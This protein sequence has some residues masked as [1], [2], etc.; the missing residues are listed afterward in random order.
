MN[1]KNALKSLS[2]IWSGSLLASGSS[3]LI[4]MILARELGVEA[5]GLF[6]SSIAT[7]ML[8]TLLAG[9][10]VS[11][12][13]LKEFGREGWN[14]LRLIQPS[15]KFIYFSTIIIIAIL[16]IWALFGPHDFDTTKVLILLSLFLIGQIG[17]EIV[18]SKFQLEE[19]YKVLALWQL[20]PNLLRL[21]IIIIV[22]VLPFHFDVFMAALIYS[23]VG[24]IFIYF[25]IKQLYS[26][27]NGLIDLK[28]H[29]KKNI[30]NSYI[31]TQ[32]EIFKGALPFGLAT[33]FGFI[34][35]QSDLIMLKY[36]V[37]D[38]E[39]GFYNVAFVLLMAI[40]IFP[41][42]LFNKFLLP[43]YHRWANHEKE[44]FYSTYLK[45]T[46]IMLLFG[47]IMMCLVFFTSNFIVMIFFG[48][49]YKDSIAL[50]QIASLNIPIS[51]V[52]YGAGA[53]LV[54]EEHMK[55]KVLFMGVV[56]VL[57]IILN[58]TLIP[59]YGAIG[60]SIS[61]VISNLILLILYLYYVN[62]YIF[63]FKGKSNVAK[64]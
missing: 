25:S 44:K 6:S 28:G 45:T 53:V 62:N 39:S 31:P 48:A 29:H 18:S 19:K 61:T 56:A 43:K 60:A 30:E 20:I 32:K 47:L 37:G 27:K 3:F 22:I 2:F 38:I 23:F 1:Y 59:L 55:K 11:K 49:E 58:F 12:F 35:Y 54:T 64:N 36:L 52:A 16:L 14:A 63:N 50:F 51:S 15:I 33:F 17:I 10:G 8:L 7:I 46:K 40:L 21:F 24:I 26:L 13:W 57:N 4:Y 5:F 42:N 41:S 9:F 34:Y